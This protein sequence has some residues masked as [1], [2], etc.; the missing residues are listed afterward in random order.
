MT[1]TWDNGAG[2]KFKRVIAVDDKYMFTVRDSVE[3]DGAEPASL[4]PYALILRRGKPNVAGYAVLHEGFVGVIGDGSVQEIT[5]AS[6]EKET[7]RVRELKGDGGWLGFTDKYWGSAII[8]DQAEPIDARFSA[9]GTAQPEDYQ[10]DF[11]GPA[12]AVAPGATGSATARV[13]AGAKEVSTIDAY[14]KDLGIKKF[15]LMIDWGW[16]YFITKPLFRVIDVIYHYVGNFGLAIL[17]R[18]RADQARLLPA[19][20]PE[21]PLDGEDEEDPAADRRAEG[22]LSRRPRQAAAGADGAVQE[23]GRQSGRRLPADGDPDPGVLRPLQGDLHHHRDAA[24]AVLRLDQ[25]P[26]RARPDQP[27]HPVRAHSVGPDR[28]ADVRPLPHARHLAADHG[29]LDVPADEDEP[30]AGRPG[31]KDDVRLDAGHFHLHA[32]LVSGRPGDLLDLEQHA[33]GA[34]AGLHHVDAPG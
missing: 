9:S 4:R 29:L 14:G 16:F 15:D 28:D 5:Y 34:S 11:V 2:L 3:N 7:G 12:I 21:L 20:Q 6:I 22:P 8:P 30:G 33:D 27:L 26:L 1:L 32:R 19:R 18:H 31:A 17:D 10:T 24:R 23:G 13:F 25:G